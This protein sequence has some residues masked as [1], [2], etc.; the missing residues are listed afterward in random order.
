MCEPLPTVDYGSICLCFCFFCFVFCIGWQFRLIVVL[1]HVSTWYRTGFH[2]SMRTL[3]FFFKLDFCTLL[4][5]TSPPPYLYKCLP[6]CLIFLLLN[7]VL[8]GFFSHYYA[9][10]LCFLLITVATKIQ[11]GKGRVPPWKGFPGGFIFFKL[12][13]PCGSDYLLSSCLTDLKNIKNTG[14]SRRW[15]LCFVILLLF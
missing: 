1:Y 5:I 8:L 10:R 3:T 12:W 6:S 15:V 13:T 11:E 14:I 9:V 2:S 7:N 4:T